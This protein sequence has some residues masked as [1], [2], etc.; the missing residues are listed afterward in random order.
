M[1]IV[2]SIRLTEINGRWQ[3][4]LGGCAVTKFCVDYGVTLELH[5][6]AGHFHQSEPRS[7]SA[8]ARLMTSWLRQLR[9]RGGTT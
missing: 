3:L 1:G 2:T 7:R 8:S 6:S 4:P 5:Q 9:Q